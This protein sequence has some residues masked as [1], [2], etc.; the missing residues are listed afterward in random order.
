ML[1]AD[2]ADEFL[3]D[4]RLAN[5][6]TAV[7]TDLTALGEGGDQVHN[8]DAGLQ[9]LDLR[10]LILEGR[11]LAVDGPGVAGLYLFEIVERLAQRV[12]EPAE[13]GVAH[14][15]GDR[16]AGVNCVHAANQALRRSESK[17]AHPVVA[18]VLFDFKDK[19][20]TGD[21]GLERVVD[22]RHLLRGE[23]HVHHGADDLGYLSR[24]HGSSVRVIS[25]Q[26]SVF[27]SA[28]FGIDSRFRGNNYRPLTLTLS[29]GEREHRGA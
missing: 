8:L 7:S 28:A 5:A 6:R 18:D 21:A 25:F 1:L 24:C 15:N 27:S 23:L 14:G 16:L 13:C 10:S 4:N 19:T 26:S 20:L 12:E 2:V 9:N 29:L 17:A 11:G 3:D 22:R